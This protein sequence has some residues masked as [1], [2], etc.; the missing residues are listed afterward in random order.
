MKHYPA[1]H[2]LHALYYPLDE[3]NAS[4]ARWDTHDAHAAQ[5]LAARK[6][7]AQWACS[8]RE[9]ILG[10]TL[11]G[12]HAARTHLTTLQS[13]G[14]CL[15]ALDSAGLWAHQRKVVLSPT[16]SYA[17][18]SG[19]AVADHLIVLLLVNITSPAN[20]S[21]SARRFSINDFGAGV[22]QYGAALLAAQPASWYLA[23]DGAGDVEWYTS[24]FVSFVD[25]T[26]P[27][28]ALPRAD[29][30][31]SLE[32]GEHIPRSAERHFVRNLH[33]H[34]CRG[35]VLSW[36][37]YGGHA[38]INTRDNA[39]IAA[40]FGELGYRLNTRMTKAA[41]SVV[42]RQAAMS[43]Q[44][45]R[46]RTQG[47]EGQGQPGNSSSSDAEDT[48]HGK[49]EPVHGWFARSLMVFDRLVPV[50]GT[51]CTSSESH[52]TFTPQALGPAYH[53]KTK[54]KSAD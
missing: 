11:P 6:L 8:E 17:L 54:S 23:Y 1:T 29:W 50:T 38:H 41:R 25:L 3:V 20:A 49:R 16:I 5:A 14:W 9:R 10:R 28:L 39:Y 13:G 46:Q 18:P 37:D 51:G 44:P 42:F 4:A 19:H 27:N 52:L 33:A 36:A 31:L 26:L 32:T 53:W 40:L 12:E 15:K 45:K 21:R 30:V 35:I 22:G 48:G 24:G 43:A 34:N 47:E 2:P 7:E